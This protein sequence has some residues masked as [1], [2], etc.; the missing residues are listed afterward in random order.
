MG[1][2]RVLGLLSAAACASAA[3]GQ[4]LPQEGAAPPAAAADAP[5]AAGT[6]IPARASV[7]IEITQAF[8][9][10]TAK[11]GDR[12]TIRLAEPLVVEGR[13]LLPAGLTG[14]GE[15]VHAAR[16]RWGGKPGELVLAARFLDCG[17]TRIPLGY[18]EWGAVGKSRATE[19]LVSSMI[20]PLAGLVVNGGEMDVVPGARANAKVRHDVELPA[21]AQACRAPGSET[22]ADGGNR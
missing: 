11:G 1:I 12:F 17:A 6:T 16:A 15:V 2:V 19:A 13:T 3:I 9:S 8:G 21:A 18:F 7:D 4:V 10:K 22:H 20:I 5:Q 14:E